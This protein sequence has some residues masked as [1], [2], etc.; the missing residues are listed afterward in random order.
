MVEQPDAGLAG[1]AD[2]D[3]PTDPDG[4]DPLAAY[5]AFDR[6]RW[7]ALRAA[8]PLTLTEDDLAALRGVNE[9][10]PLEEV[11]EVYLPLSRLL[12]LRV[13]AHQA[14]G[15][16]TARFLGDE[17]G[18][19][20]PFVVAIAGSVAVGKSTIARIVRELLSRWPAHPR[21]DLVTTDGFLLPNRVLEERGLAARKGF[22]E[23]YDLPRL[24]RFLASLKAGRPAVAAPVYS[25]LAYDVL[26]G[27]VRLVRRPDVLVLEG[28]N[29]LQ[30]HRP[31][32]PRLAVSDFFDFSI[33]VDAQEADVARW[34]EERF[35]ALRATAFRSPESYFHRYATLDDAA[36]RATAARIWRTVN[37]V[38]LAENIRPTRDR[39]SLVLEKGPD[40]LVRRVLLRR[41]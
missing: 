14:L 41:R 19:A 39:A 21:V 30:P 10:M 31:G 3:R 6:T 35:L 4:Q 23:S 25:H 22:P 16:A 15:D 1:P 2:P 7:A 32:P 29:V 9:Y 24:V 17:A 38:N 36:A 34:Y 26:P 27:E 13:Q 33:Y 12:D 8:T 20:A 11:V 28:L 40:H 37:A 5:L 18:P